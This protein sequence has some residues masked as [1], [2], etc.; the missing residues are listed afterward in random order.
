MAS[1]RL[2][3]VGLLAT[4]GCLLGET[5][6]SSTDAEAEPSA[7]TPI[8]QMCANLEASARVCSSGSTPT[9]SDDSCVEIYARCSA[10]DLDILNDVAD[11][12]EQDCEDLTCFDGFTDLSDACI[13]ISSD[14]SGT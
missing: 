14:T 2:A 9:Q 6:R 13:G 1:G 12:W 11:C 7:Q 4:V 10:N 5:E 8:E 3:S